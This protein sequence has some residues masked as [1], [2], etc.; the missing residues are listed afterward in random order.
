MANKHFQRVH[1]IVKV[2]DW[3][4]VYKSKYCFVES[5]S[6]ELDSCFLLKNLEYFDGS[7]VG[8]FCKARYFDLISKLVVYCVIFENLKS[9]FASQKQNCT[10]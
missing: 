2:T 7:L 8:S 9:L 10:H 6:W 3:L 4:V 5:K 1:F